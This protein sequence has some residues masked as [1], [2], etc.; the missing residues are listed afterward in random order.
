MY[1]QSTAIIDN[2]NNITI[3]ITDIV[4]YF[5]NTAHYNAK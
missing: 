2:A 1:R 4:T 3:E 5:V